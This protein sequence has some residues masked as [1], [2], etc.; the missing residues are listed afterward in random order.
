[1]L[2]D[3]YT[4][5]ISSL[6]SGSTA[7]FAVITMKDI[8]AWMTFVAS[9]VSILCGVLGATLYIIKLHKIIVNFIKSKK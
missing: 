5:H 8:Q 6:I 9:A 2:D 4:A 7:F 3:K 1:M